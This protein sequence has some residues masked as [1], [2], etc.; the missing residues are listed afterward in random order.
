[1]H[2]YIYIHMYIFS[3]SL[4]SV[5]LQLRQVLQQLDKQ[6]VAVNLVKLA[7]KVP[8]QKIQS[9]AT[10]V[11]M[12]WYD[13]PHLS[14]PVRT[15][16]YLSVPVRT[17]PYLS[18]PGTFLIVRVVTIGRMDSDLLWTSSRKSLA[19]YSWSLAESTNSKGWNSQQIGEYSEYSEYSISLAG[20]IHTTLGTC[21]PRS[22]SN[23]L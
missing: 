15:C 5:Q 2:I 6:N 4:G 18:V 3:G 13:V 17:C 14:A 8:K 7:V 11:R 1:M 22:Y 23:V 10:G 16:P 21:V 20:W 9:K 19:I 12:D